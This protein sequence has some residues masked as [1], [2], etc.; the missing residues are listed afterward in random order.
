MDLSSL[1]EPGGALGTNLTLSDFVGPIL[2]NISVAVGVLSFFTILLAGFRYVSS[3]GNE[4]EIQN[5]TNTITYAL[6]G[7]GLSLISYWFTVLLF[8]VGGLGDI[9]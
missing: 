3:A 6:I 4:K 5:A 8:K 1:Y 9:F 2:Q 7:L